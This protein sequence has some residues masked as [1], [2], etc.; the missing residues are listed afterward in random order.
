[1]A[2]RSTEN[3]NGS[4]KLYPKA[5]PVDLLP[6]EN[7]HPRNKNIRRTAGELQKVY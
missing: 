7:R 2:T 6:A 1:M 4:H 3:D 5:K